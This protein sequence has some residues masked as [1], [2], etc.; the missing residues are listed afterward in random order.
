M[1][2]AA[3]TEVSQKV[4]NSEDVNFNILA[5]LSFKQYNGE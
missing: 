2:D 1:D 3:D 5:S 4:N